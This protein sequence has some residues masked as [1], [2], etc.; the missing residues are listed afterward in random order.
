MARKR[1]D[2]AKPF[3]GKRWKFRESV[4]RVLFYLP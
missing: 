3:F 1:P 4:P 2:H